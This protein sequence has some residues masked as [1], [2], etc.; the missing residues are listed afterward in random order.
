MFDPAETKQQF[1]LILFKDKIDGHW[2]WRMTVQNAKGLEEDYHREDGSADSF[3][4]AHTLVLDACLRI[5][6]KKSNHLSIALR[7]EWNVIP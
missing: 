2:D 3:E 1:H 5:I 7:R 6:A 4:R